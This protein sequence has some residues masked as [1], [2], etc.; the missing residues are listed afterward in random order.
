MDVTDDTF[1]D[2]SVRIL[3]PRTGHRAGVDA[4][5]LAASVAVGDGAQVLDVGA[6]SGIVG[7]LIARRNPG[8]HV[9]AVEI[10][11]DMAALAAQNADRNGLA[12]RYRVI[13]ADLTA[14]G[15]RL[16][17]LGLV[18]GSFDH[19]VANPPYYLASA[20]QP[21]KSPLKRR[22]NSMPDSDLAHWARFLAGMTRAGGT[23][24]LI[25]RAEALPALFAHLGNR[26]GAL[27]VFPLF[28]KAGQAAGRMLL[29]GTKGSR[30]PLKLLPGLVLHEADGQF[31]PEVEQMLR[32]GAPLVIG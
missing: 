14:P 8:A 30:A 13:A 27:T 24:T 11:P 25:H 23:L 1:L 16:S 22:A 18:A 21:A 5:L 31:R 10:E 4:V 17:A 32:N 9:T 20:S 3:Q 6:G 15:R 28:A 7:L 12:P 2:G 29:R 19:V 26:F